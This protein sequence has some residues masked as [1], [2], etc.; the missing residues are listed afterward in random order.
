MV[1]VVVHRAGSDVD[2]GVA[3]AQSAT[4][5]ETLVL[6]S[7]RTIRHTRTLVIVNYVVVLVLFLDGK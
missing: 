3:A 5:L 7:H 1:V 4:N 6:D 2:A